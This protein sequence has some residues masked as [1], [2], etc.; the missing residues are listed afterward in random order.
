MHRTTVI[1]DTQPKAGGTA[2]DRR[3]DTAR[4]D[5]ADGRAR[6]LASEQP[7]G[8]PWTPRAIANGALGLGQAA[9]SVRVT[10]TRGRSGMGV[11]RADIHSHTRIIGG[12]R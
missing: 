8:M 2:G 11:G 3:A 6:D 7:C 10:K 4:A 9:G 12:R 1:E 5:D